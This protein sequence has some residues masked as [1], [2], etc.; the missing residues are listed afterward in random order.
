MSI[1]F[2]VSVTV[3]V[4]LILIA[5]CGKSEPTATPT[6]TPVPPAATPT[7]TPASPTA[8]P[9]VLTRVATEQATPTTIPHPTEPP[10]A[11]A[12]VEVEE[13]SFQSDHFKLVGDLQ[14]PGTEGKH[15]VII[16]V[17]GDGGINRTDS[18]K[19]RPIMERFL[20]AGYAVFSW[21]KPGTGESTGEFVDGAW[22]LTNRASILVDAVESL[23][24]HPAIDPERIGV[25][26]ISQGGYVMPLALTMSD[27]I[28]FMIVVSGPGVNGIDQTAYL[29]GQQVLCQGYSEEEA[30]LAEQSF[31]GLCK[32]T[33]YQEYRESQENLI[34]FPCAISFTGKDLT[35]EEDWVPW[36]RQVDAFF[37]PIEVIEQTTI[38]VLA[39]FGEKDTQVDPFQGAQAYEEALQK[40]GNQN[41]HVELIP[42]VAHVLDLAETGCMNEHRARV[43]APEYLDLMEEWLGQLL[44]STD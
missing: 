41:F 42:G 6:T 38:P 34:Q 11:A 2:K 33:T 27:D 18:G 30:E 36:D 16:M 8:T 9:V 21:D 12:P 15:P 37:N 44:E 3:V 1:R 35:P 39:F 4:V 23:K 22:I 17:H 13:V 24:E 26:G 19:Y 32:A 43:Y 14:I 10:P 31:A 5:G 25:W 7:A 29:I 20:R 28:A 40:A